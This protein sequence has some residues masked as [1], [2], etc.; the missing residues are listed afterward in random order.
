MSPE[1]AFIRAMTDDIMTKTPPRLGPLGKRVGNS[2]EISI[3]IN[4]DRLNGGLATNVPLLV[5]GQIGIDALALGAKPSPEQVE[6]ATRYQL[7]QKNKPKPYT[8]VGSAVSAAR[9]RTE[10]KGFK[11]SQ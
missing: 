3:T 8:S 10:M 6:I 4:D 1:E 5:P 11:Y 9:Q 7:S 2:S